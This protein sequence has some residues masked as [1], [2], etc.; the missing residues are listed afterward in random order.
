MKPKKIGKLDVISIALGSIIGTG[1]FLLPGDFFLKKIGLLNTIAGILIGTLLIFIIENNYNFLIKKFPKSGGE[2]IFVKNTLGKNHAF[3]CGWLLTLSYFTIIPLNATAVPVVI[4]SIFPNILKFNLLYNIHGNIY[5]GEILASFIF[6]FLFAYLN[7]KGIHFAAIIQKIMV[8]FLVGII[9][10]FSAAV[11]YVNSVP[12]PVLI[13][14]LTVPFSFENILK[15]VSITP[16]LFI[17]F[18]CIPQIMEE[19]DFHPKK[20]S[21]LAILS[22][23]IGGLIY[24]ILTI[25]TAYGVSLN[26]LNTE[27]INWATGYTISLFFGKLGLIILGLAFL[28]AIIA[29]INGFYMSSSRLLLAM[30]E[31]RE[32]PIV[33]ASKKNNQPKNALI[34]LCIF[35]CIITLFGRNTVLWALDVSSVGASLAYFY[36][37]ISA[38]ILKKNK[39][40]ILFPILGSLIGLLALSLLTIPYFSTS[41][42]SASYLT[43]FIW[44]FLGFLLKHLKFKGF[45]YL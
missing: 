12:S 28:I 35:S 45:A 33:F 43:L 24:I 41:L 6:L 21:L 19:L 32:L 29:G 17:G 20:V 25:I 9:L 10:C 30:A 3:I 14:N 15:I 5:L 37:S 38:L 11:I 36:T 31:D 8:F 4:N 34:I 26:T 7:I 23:L 1:A 39:E 16:F 40:S 42:N 27:N 44:I 2:Y 18:D 22:V 13:E